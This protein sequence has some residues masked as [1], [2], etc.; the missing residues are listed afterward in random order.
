MQLS[1]TEVASVPDVEQWQLV[2]ERSIPFD[3][4]GLI[5]DPIE[6]A[7]TRLTEHQ[8]VD[9]STMFIARDGDAVVGNAMVTLPLLDNLTNAHVHLTVLP[10]LR[11]RGIGRALVRHVLDV[12]RAEGRT[13]AMG[14]VTSPMDAEGPGQ[15]LMR[16]LG[17]TR[18][19]ENLRREADLS[20][21]NGPGLDAL[22]RDR[23]GGHADEYRVV[24]WIDRAPDAL[25]DGAARLMG[26][27]STDAPQGDSSW[28]PEAW[29]AARY[30]E[31]E[32]SVAR[33]Q[34]RR[35]VAGAIDATDALVA[36]SDIGARSFD[37]PSPTSGTPWSTPPTAATD[38]DSRSRSRT[39]AS[40]V[41]SRLTP[42]AS[43]PGT[44]RRTHS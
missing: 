38:W 14:F 19:N 43:R 9:R 18:A 42:S 4:P 12:A 25:V 13:T 15:A 35:F 7:L 39:T 2:E 31:S 5:A 26:R 3:H 22:L 17:A 23:V 20:R 6:E 24:T 16:S 41:A 36:Y 1:I 44:R 21:L 28:E 30:R 10:E 40:C 37:P 32:A 33:R 34:R 11:R 29:D 27:M 8:R